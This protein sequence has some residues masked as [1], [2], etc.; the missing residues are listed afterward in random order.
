MNTTMQ[1]LD[2]LQ[3]GDVIVDLEAASKP[4]VLQILSER[5]GN[6]L[7]LPGR[8]IFES[9]LAR[10]RLG[11]TGVGEGIALPHT[12]MHDLAKPFGLL[13]RLAKPLDFE[14]IDDIPVDVVC[15]L[16]LPAESAKEHLNALA[17]VTRRLRMPEVLRQIRQA[18]TSGEVYAAITGT[19]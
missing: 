19:S 16:I 17:C 1:V 2:F 12:R 10:E 11:S 13:A 18:K 5:A 6:A 8:N 4:K 15:A 9:L 7:G 3:P 14:S